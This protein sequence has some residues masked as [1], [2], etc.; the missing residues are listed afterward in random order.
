M[1]HKTRNARLTIPYP[2]TPSPYTTHNSY[3]IQRRHPGKKCH[4]LQKP[5]R[6]VGLQGQVGFGFWHGRM[7][8]CVVEGGHAWPTDMWADANHLHPTQAKIDHV[9]RLNREAN[10]RYQAKMRALR[11]RKLKPFFCFG[12]TVVVCHTYTPMSVCFIPVSAGRLN[13]PHPILPNA[14]TIPPNHQPPHT[15]RVSPRGPHA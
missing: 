7:V 3:H 11:V 2:I 6:A 14:H 9:R 4:V 1:D 15:H 12:D 5:G 13:P 10:Q 8:C